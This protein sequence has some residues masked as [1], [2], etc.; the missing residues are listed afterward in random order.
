MMLRPSAM[1]RM[2]VTTSMREN[3]NSN[4]PNSFTEMRLAVNSASSTTAALTHC[5]TEGTR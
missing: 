4:S 5:G 3:Q 2:I 1:T